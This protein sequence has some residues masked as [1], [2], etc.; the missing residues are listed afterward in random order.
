MKIPKMR[1]L[2]RFCALGAADEDY[3]PAPIPKVKAWIKDKR[4][5]IVFAR[6]GGRVRTGVRLRPGET[7]TVVVDEHPYTSAHPV[8]EVVLYKVEPIRLIT[9]L[10]LESGV[11]HIHDETFDPVEVE[12]ICSGLRITECPPA[13]YTPDPIPKL[14]IPEAG[15]DP[16]VEGWW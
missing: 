10:E 11:V 12:C 16:L 5:E 3:R 13:N 4:L 6:V 7:R 15:K 9:A 2:W 14:S 1:G 8:D